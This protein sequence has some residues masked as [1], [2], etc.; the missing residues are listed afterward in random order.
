LL[1]VPSNLS[2]LVA[3]LYEP[4]PGVVNLDCDVTIAVLIPILDK[5][6]I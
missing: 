1:F 4:G 3:K 6:A 5:E 2:K